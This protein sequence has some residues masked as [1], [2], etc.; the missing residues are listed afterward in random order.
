MMNIEIKEVLSKKD[1]R[2]FV[3]FPY[4]LYRGNKYWVP[5]LLFDEYNTLRR[6]RNPAFEHCDVKYWLALRDGNV[7]GRVAAILNKLHLEKWDQPYV[8]F[9]WIEF[10]DDPT[11]SRALMGQV[12]D[13]AREKGMTAVHGPLGFTDLDNEGLLIEGFDELGTL[14]TIY[15][16]PYYP[17]HLESLGYVKDIDWVEYELTVPSE[18]DERI[19]KAAAII[20]KRNNLHMLKV[21]NKRELLTYAQDLFDLLDTEYQHLYGT[22]PLTKKQMEVY[23]KQYFG[24]ITADFAPAVMDENNR[25]VAFAIVLPSLSHALQKSGGAIFPFGF[26]H[27]LKALKKN[28]RADLYLVAVRSEYQGKGLNAILIDKISRVFIKMGIDKA[29]SNPELETN[30]LVQAQWKHFESRQ[31][32]RRRCFIKHLQPLSEA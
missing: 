18:P 32:K 23:I 2:A 16:H 15:N 9:G 24:F 11:V 26:L 22:V 27:L 29:E 14:A 21:K 5:R 31:H 28:N 30:H 13:W 17:T 1:L 3:R 12:E 19:A 20:L 6:D 4:E 8:R 10:I 7:V 25:M